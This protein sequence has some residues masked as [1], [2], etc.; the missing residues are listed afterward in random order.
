MGEQNNS[1]KRCSE[2]GNPPGALWMCTGCGG[3]IRDPVVLRVGPD[4]Q[5][6]AGCLRCAECQCPLEGSASC[7]LRDGR[8]LCR[9]DYNRMFAVKCGGCRLAVLPADMVLKAGGHVYHPECLRCSLC[10]RLLMPGDHFT[11]GAL[12]LC[13]QAE[14]TMPEQNCTGA[15]PEWWKEGTVSRDRG[16]PGRGDACWDRPRGRGRAGGG[17]VRVRTVLSDAQ[18]RA[19]RSCYSR[20]PRPDARVK[21]R[22]GQLTGLSSRVIRVWFQNKRCKDKRSSLRG[23]H[24]REA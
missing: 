17:G 1:D 13:C 3:T 4:Q 2:G 16:R 6:H 8:T 7:F 20:T 15:K 21:L 23:G 14:R 11:L 18:L 24:G 12:G 9:G 5:W 22:L 19:L 10:H